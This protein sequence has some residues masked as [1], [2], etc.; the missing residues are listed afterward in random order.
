M[1]YEDIYVD[2]E[3]AID[4]ELFDNEL[5]NIEDIDLLDKITIIPIR[6][7]PVFPGTITPVII[8]NS[9]YIKIIEEVMRESRT[10][11][12]VMVK[13]DEKEEVTIEDLYKNGTV[14]IIFRKI[15]LPDGSINV[16]INSV[17]RFRI[18]SMVLD[19]FEIVADVEYLNDI[20]PNKKN[21]VLKALTKEVLSK[22]KLLS[23]DNPLF[24]E[25]MKLTMLNVD[26]PGRIADYVVSILNLEKEQYQ[27]ILETT[28]VKNRLS[29]VLG[30]LH[31]E[32][33]VM[34]VQKKIQTRIDNRVDKQQREYF[35]REQL[36]EIKIELGMEEDEQV[37]LIKELKGKFD[38]LNLEDE[39]KERFFPYLGM[40]ELL[41]KLT[42]KNQRKF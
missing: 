17:K 38:K 13:D 29:L 30:I 32:I 25:E 26:E 19:G 35:L 37:L 33:D 27:K 41:I 10:I 7:R 18:K 28:N 12:I 36:K 8:S 15:N 5:L 24:T 34:N 23:D 20:L 31:K 22:L 9:K 14:S 11:G 6:Y 16:L 39:V 4:V 21:I 1:E 3:S 42:S 2:T 40:K